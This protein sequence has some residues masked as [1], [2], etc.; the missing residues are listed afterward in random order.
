MYENRGGCMG[1]VDRCMRNDDG[2][3]RKIMSLWRMVEKSVWRIYALD[4]WEKNGV[5]MRIEVEVEY[6]VLERLNMK[7]R[8]SNPC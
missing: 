3:M 7:R 1:D 6:I 8:L 2:S 5:C 4:W